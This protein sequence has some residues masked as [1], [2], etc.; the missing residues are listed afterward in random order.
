VGILVTNGI[1]SKNLLTNVNKH[2]NISLT[3]EKWFRHQPLCFCKNKIS[4]KR[5]C[6]ERNARNPERSNLYLVFFGRLVRL[7]NLR[8]PTDLSV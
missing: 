8:N 6:F 7:S 3:N 1:F 5:L 4:S 2:V